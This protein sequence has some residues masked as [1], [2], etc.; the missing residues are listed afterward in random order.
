[1]KCPNC[2]GRMRYD[3]RGDRRKGLPDGTHLLRTWYCPACYN[4]IETDTLDRT[5]PYKPPM[6]LKS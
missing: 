4:V 2:R 3:K 1:M 5:E 6:E